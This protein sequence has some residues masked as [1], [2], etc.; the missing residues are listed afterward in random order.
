MLVDPHADLTGRVR[1]R[2]ELH[3]Q[4]LGQR[5]DQSHDQ[6]VQQAR[7]I[8]AELFR[9]QAGERL[10]RDVHGHAVILCLRI[11]H[12]AQLQVDR[13]AI[14]A[15]RV[16]LVRVIGQTH[17][18]RVGQAL[19]LLRIEIQQVRI[20]VIHALPPLA[21]IGHRGHVVGNPRVVEV[22]QVLVAHRAGQLT[23]AA[24]ILRGLLQHLQV[25]LD[26]CVMLEPLLDVALH[27]SLADQ[28]VA[29]LG[30]VDP[31][32]L[33]GAVL[34]D[35]QTVQQHLRARHGRTARAGPV[36]LGVGGAGQVARQR[37]RPR[38]VDGGRIPRPQAAGLHQLGA[39]DPRRRGLGH[40]GGRE[41]R[42]P[43]AA[44]ALIVVLRHLLRALHRPRLRRTLEAGEIRGLRLAQHLHAH[45]REQ[46]GQ[47]GGVDALRIPGAAQRVRRLLVDRQLPDLQIRA[48]D[49]DR[50]AHLELELAAHLGQ[51]RDQILPLAHAQPA[52]ILG[53]AD[54]PQRRV[55]GVAVGLEHA[56]PDVQRGQE[57]AGR[58]GVTVVDAVGLVA[59]LLR[60]L[61]RILQAQERHHHQHGGQ[62][63]RRGRARRL[64]HHASQTHINR[65][66]GQLAADMR[67]HHAALTAGDG[68]ELHQLVEAVGDGLHIRRVDEPERGHVLG[69]AG[70]AHAEH[71]QHHRTQRGAQDLR[72]GEPRPRLV[73]LAAVQADGDAVGHAAASAGPLV[74]A[75]LADRL[76]RQTLHLGGFRIP[77]DAGRA[78]IHH[79][80]DARHRQRGLGHVRGDNDALMRVCLEHP[81]LFLGGQPREQ[82]HDLDGVRAAHIGGARPVMVPQGGL[83]L[84]DVA[85]AGG[86]DQDVAGAGRMAGMDDQLGAGAGHGGGHIDRG[87]ALAAPALPF[88]GG[89]CSRQ[90]SIRL[91]AGHRAG[92]E[93]GHGPH[94][95]GRGA[96]W[97]VD[98]LHRVGAS[99]H[100]DHR[101]RRVQRVFEMLLELDRVD[102][103]GGD[104]ELQVT[105]AGEQR[106]QVAEQEVDVEAALMC[107][108]D[109]DGVVPA[110]LR[111][112]LDL[113]EQD[114]VGDHAQSGLRGAFVGEPHLI[115]DLVAEPDPHLGG[116]AFGD[117]A[118]GQSAG[119][120]MHDLMAVRAAA[121]FEQ[122]L[123]QLRGFAGTGLAGDDDD[124]RGAHG[125]RDLVLG[126][127]DRQLLRILEP[128]NPSSASAHLCTRI[129]RALRSVRHTGPGFR[130]AAKSQ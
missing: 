53:F 105:A 75:G 118:C 20:V 61:A 107:L 46:A 95:R 80:P 69:G 120:R 119:L 3:A 48:G 122:D 126:R 62:R 115:A 67:Q 110:Q 10:Q 109:D 52:E 33:H 36:R 121:E 113:R 1:C 73:V 94:Q 49:R 58:V 101:H 15:E 66:A 29:R 65:D 106:R 55:A 30:R 60:A 68:L 47:H 57:V 97:L 91:F 19:H 124:L 130:P 7:H 56:V 99:G 127:A 13:R 125:L 93:P 39:H 16:P 21:Q 76:D 8:P 34:H 24:R 18:L 64:D 72:L 27:Q 45:H 43:R 108:V 79:I 84:V 23:R 41:Q 26:E 2:H 88:G 42:E 25:A 28:E 71:V 86:E 123:R 128:H 35:R 100:L 63:V 78:R 12:I 92:F 54:A 9:G 102:G 116:D 117:G 114:A 111:V 40:A 104:N 70:H 74:G 37:L 31:P 44:R 90:L 17:R 77:G 32:P 83:E 22:E 98:D 11:I 87:F 129:P 85:L 4:R 6:L 112:A 89:R 51:L 82:R 103:G 50:L 38:R 96:Q 14:G 59:V 5:L 81:M